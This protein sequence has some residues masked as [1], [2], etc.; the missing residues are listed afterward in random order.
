MEPFSLN[1]DSM[2]VGVWI[3][4]KIMK[5]IFHRAPLSVQCI[6][7]KHDRQIQRYFKIDL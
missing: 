3:S 1:K 7:L 6:F 2:V 4:P 5:E